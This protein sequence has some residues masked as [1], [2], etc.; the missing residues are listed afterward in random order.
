MRVQMVIAELGVGGAEVVAVTLAA[1][2]VADGHRVAVASTPGHRVAELRS[3]GVGH[4]PVPLAGRG[5]RALAAAVRRLRAVD[6][7]DLVHAHNPKATL[8]ARLAFGRQVPVLTTLHGV[9]VAELPRAA[10]LL[11]RAAD[12]VVAVSPHLAEQ[13]VGAGFPESRIEV[14]P[15]A[16]PPPDCC[17]RESA[18]ADLGLPRHAVVGL[19]LARMVDQKRHDLL[20][21]AWRHLDGRALLLLAG[22]GP[23]RPRIDAAVA[24][25]GLAGV[26]RRLGERSDVGRLL[27]A[28]DFLVLPTDWE[29]LPIAVL[30]AMAAGLPVVASRVAGVDEHFGDAALLVAPGSAPALLAALR[31]VV[32]SAELRALLAERGRALVAER[33][34]SRLMVD[35][36]RELYVRVAARADAPHVTA[37]GTR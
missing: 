18:R 5:P 14:V 27:A 29:G 6:R 37:G 8:V 30:E 35:R 9:P 11:R 32:G 1:A 2:A 21:E 13:L 15:N 34:G 7:P 25:H 23:N 26:V 22:D 4:L 19:C 33:F 36:Y 24:R 3:A 12:R 31:D 20:L 28:S 16:V 17:D 10:R